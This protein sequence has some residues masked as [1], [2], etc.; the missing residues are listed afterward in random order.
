MKCQDTTYFD[1]ISVFY[2]DS[3][4]IHDLIRIIMT[5]ACNE[6]FATMETDTLDVKLAHERLAQLERMI[7]RMICQSPLVLT[8]FSIRIETVGFSRVIAA[9]RPA[10]WRRDEHRA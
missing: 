4:E 8:S 10:V 1:Y 3:L 7:S 6:Y 5:V 9:N 2:V